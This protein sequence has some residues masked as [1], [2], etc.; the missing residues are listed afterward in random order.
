MN[1]DLSILPD[2]SIAPSPDLLAEFYNNLDLRVRAGEISANTALTYKRGAGRF[3]AWTNDNPSDASP[4]DKLRSW[5]AY[6]LDNGTKQGA[7]N[8]WLGGVRAFFAWLTE[9]RY[10]P[11]NPILNV[12]GA[13]RHGTKKRHIRESLTDEEVR[14]VL[15]APTSKRDLAILGMM[16]YTAARG[17][18][19]QRADFDDLQTVDGRFVLF[20]QGKGHQDKDELLVINNKAEPLLRDWLAERGIKPGPLFCSLSNRNSHGR[21]SLSALRELVKHYFSLAGVTGN[22][23]T[24]SL[25]HTAIT[26]AIVSG[27]PLQKVSKELA[28]H[29]SMDTTMIYVHEVNRMADP[30]E[31]HISY[32]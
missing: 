8:T 25:R 15:A 27:V 7:V 1:A 24:H 4:A 17:I 5:K 6:L 9:L 31:D 21:L 22:K 28:R 23:T 12:K 20:V 3:M 30:V 11:Y 10:I 19:I 18:E 14:R 29:S 16:L 13:P 26:K 32:D 2:V